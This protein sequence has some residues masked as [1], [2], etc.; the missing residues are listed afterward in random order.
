[1]QAPLSFTALLAEA[2]AAGRHCGTG[3]GG[4]GGDDRGDDPV[5]S[6]AVPLQAGPGLDPSTCSEPSTPPMAF[7]SSGMAPPAS[8]WPPADAAMPWT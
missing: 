4:R 6:L 2:T 5:L 3:P 8:A 1:V 7:A